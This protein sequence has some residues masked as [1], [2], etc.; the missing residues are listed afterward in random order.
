MAKTTT[1]TSGRVARLEAGSAVAKGSS[2]ER[3]LDILLMFQAGETVTVQHIGE[4]FG[5]SRSSTYRDISFLKGRGFIEEDDSPG[6][7]RLG[8]A[9]ERLANSAGGRRNLAKIARPHLHHLADETRESVLLC[10]RSGSRVLLVA[11]VDS[12]QML[13]VSMPAADNQPLHSGSFAKLLLAHQRPAVID[14]MLHQPIRRVGNR[15]DTAVLRRE[16]DL[17]RQRGYAASDGEVESGT[18]SIS[19]PVT[20]P[21]GEVLAALTVAAPAS[22]FEWRRIRELLPLMRRIAVDIIE[23]WTEA[24]T[25]TR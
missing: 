20:T 6:T 24:S 4:R 22:R 2:P 11:Y 8:P 14:R 19:V 7:F 9:I 1:A 3:L 25:P 15:I 5:S 21:Q 17:I 10:R 12:P 16:L 13:R 23:D 18:R